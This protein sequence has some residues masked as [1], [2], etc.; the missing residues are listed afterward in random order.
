MAQNRKTPF[1]IFSKR[2]LTLK[3]HI[4]NLYLYQAII[5]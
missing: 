3:N 5:K 2:N 4:V 1:L